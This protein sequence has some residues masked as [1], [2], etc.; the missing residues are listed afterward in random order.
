MAKSVEP[1]DKKMAKQLTDFARETEKYKATLTTL[2]GDFY[3]ASGENLREDLSRLYGAI[4]GFP[5]KPS[6]TSIQRLTYFEG[7]LKEVQ[8]KFDAYT[9]QMTKLNEGL[10][11][12]QKMPLKIKTLQ[13]YKEDK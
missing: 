6:E 4:V 3:V 5:G 10:V 1:T 9:A 2:D 12:A 8:T 11:K 13:E 7:K